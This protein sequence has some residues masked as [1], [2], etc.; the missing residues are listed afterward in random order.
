MKKLILLGFF[1]ILFSC[2]QSQPFI[3]TDDEAYMYY[4][5]G[6]TAFGLALM[7]FYDNN[8]RCPITTAEYEEIYI[9]ADS[10]VINSK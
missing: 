7:E 1:P 6:K 10:I 2:K 8:G 4:S 5:A 3:M 9:K